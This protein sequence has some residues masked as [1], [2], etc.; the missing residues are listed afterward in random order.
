M[1][2]IPREKPVL[3]NLNIYYLDV[4]KL[5]EHYQGEIGSGGVFFKCHTAEAVIFFDKDDLLNAVY[6]EKD[7]ELFGADAIDRIINDGGNYNL[8][9]NVY[10][11]ALDEVYFWSSIPAAEK[12]Y[13]DLSTEFTDL[14][15]KSVV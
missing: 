15:R 4:R 11:I 1:V 3:E 6:K 14:D 2:I 9:V 8:L 10:K 13:K 12:I 7:L 5:L